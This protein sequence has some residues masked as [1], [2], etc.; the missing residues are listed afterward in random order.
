MSIK[1]QRGG[2]VCERLLTTIL[3]LLLLITSL[4]R[5]CQPK[6]KLIV[7]HLL[8][9]ACRIEQENQCHHNDHK[10]IISSSS[11]CLTKC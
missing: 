5:F 6:V 8:C 3:V 4:G 2:A 9:N 10:F 11:T 7:A 1:S